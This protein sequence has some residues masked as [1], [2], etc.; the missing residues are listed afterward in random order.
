MSGFEASMRGL[1]KRCRRERDSLAAKLRDAE[2]ALA[3]LEALIPAPEKRP[4]STGS[5]VDE[6]H[7]ALRAKGGLFAAE[8]AQRVK[9]RRPEVSEKTIYVFISKE[10]TEG[11]IRATGK[12]RSY[13]YFTTLHNNGAT[14]TN[15]L[16]HHAT[17]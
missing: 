17:A 14:Q 3:K 7:S 6:I 15:G 11:R 2:A 10:K 13:R 16:S 8:I 12:T 4:A 5:I 1:V 9:R